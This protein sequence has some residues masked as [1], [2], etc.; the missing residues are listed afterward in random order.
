MRWCQ[1]GG[2]FG[3]GVGARAGLGMGS[4]LSLGLGSSLG[5][6]PGVGLWLGLVGVRARP[7]LTLG[8]VSYRRDPVPATSF[9]F[10][11]LYQSE[12]VPTEHAGGGAE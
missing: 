1:V 5:L 7:W 12:A 8:G 2:L 3:L 11:E 4:V 9:L 10:P 6:G